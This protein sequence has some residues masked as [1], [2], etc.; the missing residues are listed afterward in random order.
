MKKINALLLIFLL[1]L[2]ACFITSC[3]EPEAPRGTTW[4]YGTEEPSDALEAVVGDFYMKTDTNEVYVLEDEGWTKL[5]SLNGKDGVNGTDGADGTAWLYDA[6]APADTD[7]ADG[8]FWLN[9]TTAELYKKSSG[10]WELIANL[11]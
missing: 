9:T 1:L 4:S 7:G 6:K 10:K 2:S 5:A 8:N 11:K 3:S